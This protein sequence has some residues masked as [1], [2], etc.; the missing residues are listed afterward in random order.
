VSDVSLSLHNMGSF[1]LSPYIILE[2]KALYC[3]LRTDRRGKES[4]HLV[5]GPVKVEVEGTWLVVHVV[6][7]FSA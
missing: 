5:Q 6:D 1:F 2:T 3:V 4:E 7:G